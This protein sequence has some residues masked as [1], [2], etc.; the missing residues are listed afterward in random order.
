MLKKHPDTIA[1][2]LWLAR[3][4]IQNLQVSSAEFMHLRGN[5]SGAVIKQ[6]VFQHAKAQHG[7]FGDVPAYLGDFLM[8]SLCVVMIRLPD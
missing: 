6:D 5:S 7:V 4:S 8:F 1:A 2:S 3:L